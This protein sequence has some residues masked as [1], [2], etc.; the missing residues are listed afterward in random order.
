MPS[1]LAACRFWCAL[2]LPD[3]VTVFQECW[4]AAA[5]PRE[6]MY[7]HN[8]CRACL[9]L[10]LCASAADGSHF[11]EFIEG[12]GASSSESSARGRMGLAR[13]TNRNAAPRARGTP[14]RFRPPPSEANW[15]GVIHHVPIN[16]TGPRDDWTRASGLE[17]LAMQAGQAAAQR[18]GQTKQIIDM[19]CCAN[20]RHTTLLQA[21]QSPRR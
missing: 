21:R 3:G 8:Q 1:T 5:T 9:L 6:P 13:E 18:F 4:A 16:R 17:T 19:H 15:L 2:R 14:Y 10:A 20:A 11:A 12:P 7:M